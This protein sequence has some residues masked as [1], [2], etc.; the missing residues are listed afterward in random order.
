MRRDCSRIP[1]C[2]HRERRQPNRGAHLRFGP[3]QPAWFRL[4]GVYQ[5]SATSGLSS[6]VGRKD[7]V[8]LSR[9]SR[10]GSLRND[11]PAFDCCCCSIPP[12]QSST[13]P[14]SCGYGP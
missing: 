13:A 14:C 2:S 4:A 9:C 6:V 5:D 1:P 3:E 8:E 7:L 11:P 10:R 12:E